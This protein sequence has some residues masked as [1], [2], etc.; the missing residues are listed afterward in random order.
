[1]RGR[2]TRPSHWRPFRPNGRKYHRLHLLKLHN[3]SIFKIKK[4]L[5][6]NLFW[7]LHRN[8]HPAHFGL[9]LWWWSEY[10]RWGSPGELSFQTNVPNLLGLQQFQ[11][12]SSHTKP[13]SSSSFFFVK[14]EFCQAPY[15]LFPDLSATISVSPYGAISPHSVQHSSELSQE[16]YKLSEPKPLETESFRSLSKAY[17]LPLG[18]YWQEWEGT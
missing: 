18:C 1:M 13:S 15:F 17:I 10:L 14:W 6:K 9:T 11:C 7:E 3:I 2:S 12:L 8:C 4:E 16:S 5:H